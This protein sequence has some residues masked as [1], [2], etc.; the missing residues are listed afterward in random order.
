MPVPMASVLAA[1][2]A[3]R[4]YQALQLMKREAEILLFVLTYS[5]DVT[6]AHMP[7]QLA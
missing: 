2:G 5:G 6:S 7:C 4:L 1:P 3:Q